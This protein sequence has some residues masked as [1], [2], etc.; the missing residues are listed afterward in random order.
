MRILFSILSFIVLSSLLMGAAP[1][2]TRF[3]C[4]SGCDYAE[5]A[6]AMD[7]IL[8][9][10]ASNPYTIFIYPGIYTKPIT[11]KSYVGLVGYDQTST[12][13]LGTDNDSRAG[14]T[15]PGGV[16][17]TSFRGLTVGNNYPF[18]LGSL[19]NTTVEMHVDHCTV[20]L[21]AGPIQS[22]TSIDCWKD[23]STAGGHIIYAS[24]VMLNVTADCIMPTPN[25]K[26]IGRNLTV[27]TAKTGSSGFVRPSISGGWYVD[28]DGITH[29]SVL[30]SGTDYLFNWPVSGGSAPGAVL[31]IRN[32][33]W[34][35]TSQW[36]GRGTVGCVNIGS[37][38]P[39]T[40]TAD[41]QFTNVEC[42]VSVV[43]EEENSLEDVYGYIVANDSDLANYRIHV[44][45]GSIEVAGE[46]GIV[47]DVSQGYNA[48]GFLFEMGSVRNGGVFTGPG[49]VSAIV[50]HP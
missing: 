25:S 23:L 2:Q 19:P 17:D 37:V 15:I 42:S 26:F 5:P 4:K 36:P 7:S 28:I 21:F 50:Y 30:T 20:G 39:A 14:I 27:I 10:S 35:V 11:M 34:K 45:G 44:Q 22:V 9:N 29:D 47:A 13:I 3:V 41:F 48:G 43:T 1:P 32:V 16:T 12:Y 38:P 31:K 18:S 40:T 49:T 6:D 46:N 33:V 24:D 8:D